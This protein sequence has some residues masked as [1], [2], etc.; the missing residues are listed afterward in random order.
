MID[1]LSDDLKF[2]IVRDGKTVELPR[3]VGVEMSHYC[4]KCEKLFSITKATIELLTIAGGCSYF[5][6]TS[7]VCD[8][9]GCGTTQRSRSTPCHRPHATKLLDCLLDEWE[10][11]NEAE[12]KKRAARRA[13]KKQ[14]AEKKAKEVK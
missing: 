10:I 4:Y 6:T 2:K 12:R 7:Y 1:E 13:K 8:G 3:Y 5:T 14:E 9:C 11:K